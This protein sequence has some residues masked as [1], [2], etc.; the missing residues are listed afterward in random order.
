M[1]ALFGVLYIIGA[2]KNGHRSTKDM[3]S[4]DGCNIPI[5]ECALSEKRFLFLL[6][7]IRF[8]DIRGRDE[9]KK[10]DKMTHV[11]CSFCDRARDRK[12]T[13]VCTMCVKLICRDH[14][15]EVCPE[16]YAG[17]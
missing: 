8:D 9:R 2:L 16:C 14:L 12:T 1:K 15:I 7:C 13:K 11:R 6:R 5:L 3:W 17:E 10:S 4:S